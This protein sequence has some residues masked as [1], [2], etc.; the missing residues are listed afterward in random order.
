MH[1]SRM[2][3]TSSLLRAFPSKVYMLDLNPLKVLLSSYRNMHITI[4]VTAI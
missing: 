3:K 1:M 4:I 2:V